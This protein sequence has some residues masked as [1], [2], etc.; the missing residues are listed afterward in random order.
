[1]TELLSLPLHAYVVL[2]NLFDDNLIDEGTYLVIMARMPH[3]EASALFDGLETYEQRR[4][5]A[6]LSPIDAK[7]AFGARLNALADAVIAGLPAEEQS[8]VASLRLKWLCSQALNLGWFFAITSYEDQTTGGA[9][10]PFLNQTRLHPDGRPFRKVFH[11]LHGREFM[12]R[13]VAELRESTQFASEARR[14]LS[15]ADLYRQ[16]ADADLLSRWRQRIDE[17]RDIARRVNDRV[18]WRGRDPLAHFTLTPKQIAA[19]RRVVKRALRTALRV[20]PAPEISKFARG[21]TIRIEG[22]TLDLLIERSGSLAGIGPHQLD[23]TV[24]ERGG[25]RL[26]DLCLYIDGTPALDQLTGLALAMAAG[27]EQEILRDANLI[28]VYPAGEQHPLLVG[29]K[30]GRVRAIR[31]VDNVVRLRDEYVERTKFRWARELVR[32]AGVAHLELA[33]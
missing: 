19:R 11:R 21:E 33:A 10:E 26:A 13:K 31:D 6:R 12:S 25:K 15:A 17:E 9:L 4:E 27:E 24:A 5:D 29:R 23:I 22:G 1:M 7:R 14:I 28:R 32:F 8:A 18:F 2:D 30:R 20:L 16:P 3:G